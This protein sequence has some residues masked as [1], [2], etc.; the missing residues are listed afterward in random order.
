[1]EQLDGFLPKCFLEMQ[2][3]LIFVYHNLATQEI[4]KRKLCSTREQKQS[5]RSSSEQMQQMQ[6]RPNATPILPLWRDKTNFCIFSPSVKVFH[7]YY[8]HYRNVLFL[9]KCQRIRIPKLQIEH[10]AS[11]FSSLLFIF[12][13]VMCDNDYLSVLDLLFHPKTDRTINL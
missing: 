3:R 13:R 5:T 11:L 9:P 10:R 1:M 8:V 6:S 7:H 4:N 2:P 12:W